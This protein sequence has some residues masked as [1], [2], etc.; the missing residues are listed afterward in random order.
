MK[1]CSRRKQHWAKAGRPRP[2]IYSLHPLRAQSPASD[3]YLR[4]TRRDHDS[5]RPRHKAQTQASPYALPDDRRSPLLAA[6]KRGRCG[7]S[8]RLASRRWQVAR[9]RRRPCLPP[10]TRNSSPQKHAGERSKAGRKR[11]TKSTLSLVGENRAHAAGASGRAQ[12]QRAASLVQSPESRP[13]RQ[14][15][16]AAGSASGVEW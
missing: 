11:S 1:T 4:R 12:H 14:V 10:A 8:P 7:R 3:S 9:A 16:H 6:S 5:R 13:A 2:I 15:A